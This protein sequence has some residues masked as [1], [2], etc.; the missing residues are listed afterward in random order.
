[1]RKQPVLFQDE[2]APD[3]YEY[4]SKRFKEITDDDVT[5]FKSHAE[6]HEFD[7]DGSFMSWTRNGYELSICAD[8]PY[9]ELRRTE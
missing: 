5:F 1:M 3:A 9:Y 8:W 2:C 7:D 6:F 4:F